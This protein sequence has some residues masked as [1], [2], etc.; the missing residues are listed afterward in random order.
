MS[1]YENV[2]KNRALAGPEG[3]FG[4]EA[5]AFGHPV[6]TILTDRVTGSSADVR[7]RRG[8]VGHSQPSVFLQT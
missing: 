7:T 4:E 3:H 8:P 1:I 2:T 6:D 5:A